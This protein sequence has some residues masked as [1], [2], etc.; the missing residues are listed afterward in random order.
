LA[1]HVEQLF[2]QIFSVGCG[3]MQLPQIAISGGRQTP[4]R[5]K[6]KP[7]TNSPKMIQLWRR[8]GRRYGSVW[9]GGD[10][11][12]RRT[13]QARA[14]HRSIDVAASHCDRL[15]ALPRSLHQ[16][17]RFST[18]SLVTGCCL[19]T[20]GHFAPQAAAWAR[21]KVKTVLT[22]WS[23]ARYRA[24]RNCHVYAAISVSGIS[25]KFGGPDFARSVSIRR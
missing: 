23:S 9:L 2:D 20:N 22:R 7:T 11:S 19:R 21:T 13:P 15:S 4:C 25:R 10:E 5:V 12:G 3:D 17:D 14:C 18:Y 8:M 24:R 16:S 1:L 6:A